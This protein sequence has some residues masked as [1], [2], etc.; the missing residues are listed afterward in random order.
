M[1]RTNPGKA[2]I[3]VGGAAFCMIFFNDA[4]GA[5][6]EADYI[7]WAANEDDS[8]ATSLTTLASLTA[9]TVAAL[10]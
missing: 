5:W 3:K 7:G 6:T 1:M 2:D 4:N 9:A 8:S 10:I